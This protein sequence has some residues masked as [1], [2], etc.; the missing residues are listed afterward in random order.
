MIHPLVEDLSVLKD[1]EIENK[2]QD[3]SRKYFQTQNPEVKYQMS[4][5][6]DIYRNELSLRRHRAI[7]QQYQKRDKDLDNLIKVS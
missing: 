1:V 6:I 5:F 7:E 4:I 3:L 2:L